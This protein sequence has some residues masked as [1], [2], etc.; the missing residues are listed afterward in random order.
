VTDRFDDESKKI[1]ASNLSGNEYVAAFLRV[2]SEET[3][4]QIAA[5]IERHHLEVRV[6]AA[7]EEHVAVM[8]GKPVAG[9]WYGAGGGTWERAVAAG[10]AL[11]D[12][13]LCVIRLPG[14]QWQ[15]FVYRLD[16]QMALHKT[17]TFASSIEAQDA[18]DAWARANPHLLDWQ[19]PPA[20]EPA[21]RETP[22][23]ACRHEPNHVGPLAEAHGCPCGPSCPCIAAE[24]PAAPTGTARDICPVHGPVPRYEVATFP[25]HPREMH[26][27]CG[28]W[29]G[30]PRAAPPP[31]EPRA[32]EATDKETT[33]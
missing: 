21:P 20:S 14:G 4:R 16:A 31:A 5:H 11:D 18:A 12:C 3:A 26:I 25:D 9:E 27:P 1:D 29:V 33:S 19:M 23:C 17:E 24:T 32:G 13:A 28:A 6:G 22:R 15:G 30:H 8:E 7:A 10:G 2:S